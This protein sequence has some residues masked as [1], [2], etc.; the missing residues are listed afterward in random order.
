MRNNHSDILVLGAGPS[1]LSTA[2]SCK[3]NNPDAN[4]HVIE[5]A[6]PYNKIGCVIRDET[7]GY[8]EDL[9]LTSKDI[10]P[11]YQFDTNN[12]MSIDR[13]QFESS[14][15]NKAKSLG[16]DITY[17]TI[18]SVD[19]I[20]GTIQNV[21]AQMNGSFSASHFVD[22]TGQVA[23]IP[24]SLGLR[25]PSA[26]AFKAL[27]THFVSD[28]FIET[29]K[30]RAVENGFVWIVPIPY[31]G[32]DGKTKYQLIK[33]LKDTSETITHLNLFKSIPFLEEMGVPGDIKFLDPCN[34]FKEYVRQY[35]PFIFDNEI[36]KGENWTTV[37]DSDSTY[38]DRI[39]SG[40]D[41]A[42]LD[43]IKTG[44]ALSDLNWQNRTIAS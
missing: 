36:S 31:S 12:I 10:G 14:L 29:I 2:I 19:S 40:I 21:K 44:D 22:A 41:K 33:V 35:P 32:N 23:L 43:G 39:F 27:Y 11:I 38:Y 15:L 3:I 5:K 6:R 8:L 34:V 28:S 7:L 24:R 13:R 42:I 26:T 25:K 20:D 37:G 16:I 17:D 9:E 18:H 30:N 4:I 1:G